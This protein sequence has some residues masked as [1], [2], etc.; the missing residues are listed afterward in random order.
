MLSGLYIVCVFYY[1]IRG[2]VNF[3]A[4]QLLVQQPP[5]LFPSGLSLGLIS[6]KVT[7]KSAQKANALAPIICSLGKHTQLFFSLPLPPHPPITLYVC[8]ICCVWD[9]RGTFHV[10]RCVYVSWNIKGLHTLSLL[11]IPWTPL[12]YCPFFF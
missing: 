6:L 8:V 1:Y 5:S 12:R 9:I 4:N 10:C 2:G 7:H 11:I 3:P